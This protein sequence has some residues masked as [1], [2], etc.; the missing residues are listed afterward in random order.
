MTG[1]F[2]ST[3]AKATECPRCR[4][5][6][7]TAHDEGLRATVDLEPLADRAAEIEALLDGRWT[8]THTQWGHLVYRDASRIAAGTLRGTIHAQHKCVGTVQLTLDDLIG[9]Q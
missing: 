9:T 7:L 1:H 3:A 2:A 6:L 4:A 8:Y 5:A